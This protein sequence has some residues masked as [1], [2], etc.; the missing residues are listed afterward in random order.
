[1]KKLEKY[2]GDSILKQSSNNICVFCVSY[3]TPT[4][5]MNMGECFHAW[6]FILGKIKEETTN[7]FNMGG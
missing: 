4:N 7:T 5:L 3:S 1:M 6:M 2:R